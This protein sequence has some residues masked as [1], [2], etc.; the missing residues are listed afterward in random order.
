MKKAT[1]I[2]IF[3]ILT[4]NALILDGQSRYYRKQQPR[5]GYGVKAGINYAGQS[6]PNKDAITVQSNIIGINAGGYCNY[7]LNRQFAVQAELLASGKGSHWKDPYDDEK[8]LITYIDLPVML[9]YQPARFINIHTG[10]QIGYR[11]NAAQKDLKT[12]IKMNI[13]EYYQTFDYAFVIGAEANLPNNINLTLRY[14]RGLFSATT[15]V[16]YVDQWK[17]NFFQLSVGYRI[18]GR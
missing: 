3:I 9:R 2:F 15:N 14:A 8:D 4:A 13:N 6:T 7:F 5:F 18:K 12:G 1:I 11:V 16:M 17:N 10:P